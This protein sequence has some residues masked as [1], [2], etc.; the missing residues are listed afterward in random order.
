MWTS[1][2][3]GNRQPR[4][5]QITSYA[6]GEG[7]VLIFMPGGFEISQTI[8]AIRHTSEAKGFI[9]LPLH[10]ELPPRDQDAAVARYEPAQSSRRHQR[11]RNIADN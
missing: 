2:R 7:D 11:R 6:G 9:L 5:F 10:G 4:R 8:E 1:A 3:F